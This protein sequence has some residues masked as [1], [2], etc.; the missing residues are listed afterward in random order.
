MMFMVDSIHCVK[1]MPLLH[2]E[3]TTQEWLL[4]PGREDVGFKDLWRAG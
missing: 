4:Y 3:L 2:L 1:L